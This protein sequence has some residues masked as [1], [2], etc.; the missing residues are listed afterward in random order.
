MKKF[1]IAIL[2]AIGLSTPV[3]AELSKIEGA[4]LLETA[5]VRLLTNGNNSCTASK[6]AD[7]TY[8]TAKHCVANINN[9]YKLENELETLFLK[10]L[11]IPMAPQQNGR[12][13]DWAIINTTSDSDSVTALSIG[14]TEDIYFVMPVA[15]MGFPGN[16]E[17]TVSFGYVSALKPINIDGANGSFSIFLASY[18]GSSGSPIISLDT[19]DVIGILIEGYGGGRSG[20]YAVGIQ[21]IKEL[22]MCL[23]SAVEADVKPAHDFE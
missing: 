21:S 5:V 14:C 23:T 20:V 19:G 7:N 6:I 2:L 10:S 11:V 16:S 12:D 17:M 13:K 15:T 18:P 22:D 8:L 1:L 4:N 9:D 3:Q